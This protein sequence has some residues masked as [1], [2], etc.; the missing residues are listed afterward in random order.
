MSGQARSLLVID[1]DEF[2]VDLVSSVAET[3]GFA[4]SSACTPATLEACLAQPWDIILLDLTMPELD[5]VTTLRMIADAQPGSAVAIFSGAD[6]VSVK[7]AS[8]VAG[9]YG[10][11]VLGSLSKSGMG[12]LRE[13]LSRH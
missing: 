4:V 1:D 10:L 9:F 3:D 7:T 8:T 5:T 12:E 13:F 6:E 11:T 2:I